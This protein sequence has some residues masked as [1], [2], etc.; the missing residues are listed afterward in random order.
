MTIFN[1]DLQVANGIHNYFIGIPELLPSD[2]DNLPPL[3]DVDTYME[4]RPDQ[5]NF[6]SSKL[7]K[8][9]FLQ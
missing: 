5:N 8:M 6:A 7:M 3:K 9:Q 1:G 2:I 4:R